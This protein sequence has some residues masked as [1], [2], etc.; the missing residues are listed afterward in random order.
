MAWRAGSK[1]LDSR[2]TN[3]EAKVNVNVKVEMNFRMGDQALIAMLCM[4]PLSDRPAD[5]I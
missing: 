3:S 2:K 4:V 5:V 1:Q